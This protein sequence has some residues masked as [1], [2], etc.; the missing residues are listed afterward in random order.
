MSDKER[1]DS[2]LSYSDLTDEELLNLYKNGDPLCFDAIMLRYKNMVL[3]IAKD[4][5]LVSGDKDDLIQEGM[6][7]LYKA[8]RGYKEDSAAKFSTFAYTCI[9]RQIL[10]AVTKDNNKKN[11]PLNMSLPTEKDKDDKMCIRDRNMRV[12]IGYDVHKLVEDRD[13]IIGGVKIPYEK[14][15][16]GHSDAD[17]LLHAIS[18]AI[19]GAAALGDIGLHFPDTDERFK[20]ADSLKLLNETGKLIKAEGCLL[21]T[22]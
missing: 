14:G 1:N 2:R 7:G 5:F 19:L 21:Y 18:D 15:L 9:K 12:G 22:S 8:V 20:G 16:L 4:F 13:L 17:V 6:I 10:T 3:E 11:M